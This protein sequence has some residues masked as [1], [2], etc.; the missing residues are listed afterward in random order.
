M[1]ALHQPGS[2]RAD[3]A[4]GSPRPLRDEVV[5]QRLIDLI[6]QRWNVT[7]T[8]IE[9]AAGFGKSTAIAQAMRDNATD[10]TGVDIYVACRPPDSSASRLTSRILAQL[11]STNPQTTEEPAELADVVSAHLATRAP[12]SVSLILDDLHHLSSGD[13][14]TTL[15]ARLLRNLPTNVHVVL[16]GRTLPALPISRL[17]AADDVLT[18]GPADLVFDETEMERLAA[19]HGTDHRSLRS[20]AGWPALARLALVVGSVAPIDFLIEEIVEN[21]EEPYRRAIVAAA[22]SKRADPALLTAAGIRIRSSEI[23]ARVPLISEHD[24]GTI[25]AHDFWLEAVDRLLDREQLESVAATVARWHHAAGRLDDALEVATAY[26]AWPEALSVILTAIGGGDPFPVAGRSRSWMDRFPKEMHDC[27]ELCLLRGLT[28]RLAQEPGAGLRD[29]E[30]ALEQFREGGTLEQIAAAGFEV[31]YSAWLRGDLGRVL[32]MYRLALELQAAGHEHMAPLIA[33]VQAVIADL[34]GDPARARAHLD[35]VDLEQTPR[36]LVLYVLR[37]SCA[38]SFLLGDSVRGL[39]TARS[40]L[41][42][43]DDATIGF[44]IAKAQWHN[45]DAEDLLRAW[46][47]LRH[48]KRDHSQDDFLSCVHSCIIDASFGLQSEVGMLDSYPTDRAREHVLRALATAASL[49]TLGDESGAGACI[50]K[51]IDRVGIDDPL[52]RGELR[53][54]APLPIVLSVKARATLNADPLVDKLAERRA[55]A[56]ILIAAR[57]GDVVDWS[58]MPDHGEVCCALPLRWSVELAAYAAAD[59]HPVGAQLASYLA[60]LS[61]GRALDLLTDLAACKDGPGRGA[62]SILQ[63]MPSRPAST[64]RI[65]ACGPMRIEGAG[66]VDASILRR[67]R[68]RELLSL[69]LLRDRVS[70]EQ[71]IEV[72]WPDLDSADARNNLRITLSFVRK[73]LEPGRAPGASPFHARRDAGHV[74][75]HRSAALESDVWDIRAT[76]QRGSELERAGDFGAAIGEYRKAVQAWT[77][78]AFEDLRYNMATAAEVTHFDIALAD[79]GAQVAE[80]A[81]AQ[82]RAEEATALAHRLLTHDPYS[83]RGHVILIS[84]HLLMGRDEEARAAVRDCAGVLDE[85]GVE[86]SHEAA[87]VFRRVEQRPTSTRLAEGSRS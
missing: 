58:T 22:L 8:Q 62:A 18:I 70:L 20:T 52:L 15:L 34:E 80:W 9:A 81:L 25:S 55:L 41:T 37:E 4:S 29:S 48:G 50:D 74:W 54:F 32:D 86:P 68:V 38:L 76:L 43:S 5:R 19:S 40:L 65:M 10:P 49:V 64:I 75:L 77:G 24:D 87:M 45:G 44:T 2:A 51:V 30:R 59:G 84:A 36:P 28:A 31:G 26:G 63:S 21:L 16:S 14:S 71:A 72:V 6:A 82:G 47:P 13:S 12:T 79:A 1:S 39:E 61:D 73:L 7:L 53:R 27:P 17:I 85:L 69:L 11:G 3:E 66:P 67:T 35:T 57:R 33:I 46:G 78:D 56:N 60:D 23:A 42:W 83:E